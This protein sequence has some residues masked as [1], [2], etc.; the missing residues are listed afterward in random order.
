M[1]LLRGIAAA[2]R[3]AKHRKGSKRDLFKSL[4]SGVGPPGFSVGQSYVDTG[5]T[6]T[7]YLFEPK[8]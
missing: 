8:L 1:L 2:K 5:N 3:G 7:K 6:L 4:D